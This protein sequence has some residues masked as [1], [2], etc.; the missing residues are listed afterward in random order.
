MLKT[1]FEVGGD[2]QMLGR[3]RAWSRPGFAT[4][5]QKAKSWQIKARK[6]SSLLAVTGPE[7]IIEKKKQFQLASSSKP[8]IRQ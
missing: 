5:L 3:G 2:E 4:L 8:Q 1:I 6:L 7:A